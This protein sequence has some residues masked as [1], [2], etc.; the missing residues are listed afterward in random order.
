[1]IS[2]HCEMI[3]RHQA[4]KPGTA[5]RI[6]AA[7]RRAFGEH[8]YRATTTRAIAELAGVAEPTVFRHFGSKELLFERAV[9]APFAT[10]IEQHL[11]EWEHREPGS[12]P[13]LDETR[14][15]YDDLFDLF[16]EERTVIPAL[17]AVYHDDATPSVSRRLEE[18]M[19][20]L[21]G[22]LERRTAV[23]ART[24]G[25]SHFDVV[26][27]TRIMIAM[28][29]AVV[30]LPRLF[31]TQ[32]LQRSR[33]VEEMARLTAYGAE[34]RGQP[35]KDD[36]RAQGEPQVAAPAGVQAPMIDDSTWS[37]IGP[38]LLARPGGRRPGRRPVDDRLVLEGILHVLTSDIP[39]TALPA[40]R[41]HV[42]GVTCWRRL[43]AWQQAG[44]WS[45][46]VPLLPVSAV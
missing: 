45:E 37:R 28:A 22:M 5:E 11:E 21:I 38:I 4:S 27:L 8:G 20:G 17:L 6:L 39:W 32:G 44:V 42:S 25:N 13:I 9:V 23:E 16:S 30:T 35:T 24:R 12:V 40:D 34:F 29:F 46:V 33:V 1:M 41:Y 26:C 43:R 14:R 19:R 31:D 7:A 10:F 3:G 36:L 18:C 15:L 2:Y